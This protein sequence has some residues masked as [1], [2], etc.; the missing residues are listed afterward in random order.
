MQACFTDAAA[1]RPT[2]CCRS[3]VYPTARQL[4]F[5]WGA[6]NAHNTH[7]PVSVDAGWGLQLPA[8]FIRT[9]TSAFFG[10]WM[11]IAAAEQ[12]VLPSTSFLAVCVVPLMVIL[13]SEPQYRALVCALPRAA[14]E[15]WVV[16]KHSFWLQ[17]YTVRTNPASNTCDVC[18]TQ[19]VQHAVYGIWGVGCVRMRHTCEACTQGTC[20]L[21]LGSGML[22]LW[23]RWTRLCAVAAGAALRSKAHPLT[24][25]V[26]VCVCVCACVRVCM[27]GYKG[28]V[29]QAINC[30]RLASWDTKPSSPLT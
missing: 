20:V 30:R 4:C 9:H 3:V 24:V 10:V 13:L 25:C 2:Q 14:T 29:N 1:A 28:L 15:L 7:C 22:M 26:C 21:V 17:Q 27:I 19:L 5:V 16:A 12:T 18:C 23:A 8:T 6:R 11:Q